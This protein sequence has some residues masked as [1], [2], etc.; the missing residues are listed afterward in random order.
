MSLYSCLRLVISPQSEAGCELFLWIV[1]VKDETEV[2]DLYWTDLSV[3]VERVSKMLP[4][5]RINHFPG[6]LDICRKV[7]CV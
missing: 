1:Q 6:M 4:F 3:S 5:Q 2:W 7:R